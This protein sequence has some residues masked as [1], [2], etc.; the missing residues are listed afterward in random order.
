[1]KDDNVAFPPSSPFTQCLRVKSCGCKFLKKLKNKNAVIRI[2]HTVMQRYSTLL[3]IPTVK[4]LGIWNWIGWHPA[5]YN[6]GQIQLCPP[7]FFQIEVILRWSWPTVSQP[8][9]EDQNLRSKKLM[10]GMHWSKQPTHQKT[11]QKISS[12]FQGTKLRNSWDDTIIPFL[13]TSPLKATQL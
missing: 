13:S 5:T 3:I 6:C 1:M 2:L 9:G 7:P 10:S 11:R 8:R 4:P 12:G